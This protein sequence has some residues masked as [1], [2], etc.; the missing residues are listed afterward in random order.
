MAEYEWALS[1][2]LLLELE[3]R[4]DV[5]SWRKAREVGGA[6]PPAAMRSRRL[7]GSTMGALEGV[8]L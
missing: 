1:R 2:E 6:Q 4:L 3:A 5:K 8:G 7:I